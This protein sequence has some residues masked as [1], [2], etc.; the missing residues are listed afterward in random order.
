M[1]RY[2]KPTMVEAEL[3]ESHKLYKHQARLQLHS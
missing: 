2:D 1:G 3:R